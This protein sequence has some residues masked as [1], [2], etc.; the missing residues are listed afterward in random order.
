[1]ADVKSKEI[2][3]SDGSKVFVKKSYTGGDLDAVLNAK[4]DFDDG[5][6]FVYFAND[7][8]QFFT[9][10]CEQILDKDGGEIAVDEGYLKVVNAEDAMT[11]L[12]ELSKS[13]VDL[14]SIEKKVSGRK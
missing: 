7:C 1:M 2:I 8:R 6:R 14:M 11:I 4:L 9:I 3:L 12:V 13:V 10:L 5:T